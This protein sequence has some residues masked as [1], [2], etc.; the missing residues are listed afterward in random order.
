M[1][2]TAPAFPEAPARFSRAARIHSSICSIRTRSGHGH[3][4]RKA[5]HSG[6]SAPSSADASTAPRATATDAL[7]LGQQLGEAV[8]AARILIDNA[9]R[10]RSVMIDL[11]RRWYHTQHSQERDRRLWL[12]FSDAAQIHTRL[13]QAI[14]AREAARSSR[15]SQTVTRTRKTARLGRQGEAHAS[16]SSW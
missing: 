6:R 5:N 1:T 12:R 3:E 8:G 14:H 7:L 16:A 2:C 4:F 11:V 9:A 10:E 15:V 13:E